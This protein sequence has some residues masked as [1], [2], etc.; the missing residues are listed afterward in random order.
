MGEK[1]SSPCGVRVVS[2]C[3][4]KRSRSLRSLRPLSG[5]GLCHLKGANMT[6]FLCF[7]PLSGN[8]L[9]YLK[10]EIGL[11]FVLSVPLRGVCCVLTR[12]PSSTWRAI[13]RPLAGYS[14]CYTLKSEKGWVM[15]FPSPCGVGIVSRNEL[16]LRCGDYKFPSPCGVGIVSAKL[17][18]IASLINWSIVDFIKMR[19]PIQVTGS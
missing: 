11:F 14:L 12:C 9:C 8:G 18:R 10:R 16:C 17:N 3:P 13:I 7:R 15:G 2:L 19:S 6:S 1:R 4:K 5:C